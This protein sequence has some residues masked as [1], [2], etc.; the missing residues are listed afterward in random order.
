M[1]NVVRR[2][3]YFK[4]AGRTD[5]QTGAFHGVD[6]FDVNIPAACAALGA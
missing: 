4:V 1:S 2:S 3:D 6:R 5:Y